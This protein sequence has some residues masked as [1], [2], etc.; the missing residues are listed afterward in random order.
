M[1]SY[2]EYS[3]VEP[4]PVAKKGKG[5]VNGKKGKKTDAEEYNIVSVLSV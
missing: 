4:A 2:R 3:D 1:L 5:K